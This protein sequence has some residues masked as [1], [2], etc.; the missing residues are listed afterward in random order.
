MDPIIDFAHV[1]DMI[2]LLG[3]IVLI[4]CSTTQ[5]ILIIWPCSVLTLQLYTERVLV[6]WHFKSNTQ[7]SDSRV[8]FIQFKIYYNSGVK[9]TP[10]PPEQGRI[11][12]QFGTLRLTIGALFLIM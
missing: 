10:Q 1:S 7:T 11:I 12:A 5:P 8:L 4:C 9:T 3:A 6:S 2:V